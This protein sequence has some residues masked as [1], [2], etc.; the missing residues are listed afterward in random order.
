VRFVQLT[1]EQLSALADRLLTVAAHIPHPSYANEDSVSFR[2]FGKA[3][4]KERPRF[5]GTRTYT[6]A[7]TANYEKAV[8]SIGVNAM[9]VAGLLPYSRPVTLHIQ[10]WEAIPVS[11]NVDKKRLARIGLVRPDKNDLDNVIKAILDA[12]NGVVFFDDSLVTQIYAVRHYGAEEEVGFS[13]SASPCGI[14]STD[15]TNLIHMLTVR[16]KKVK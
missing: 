15:A 11:W 1:Q 5:T 14:S 3:L 2:F 8:K 4:P 13:F 6:T 12:L 9:K 7:K 16:R 10:V